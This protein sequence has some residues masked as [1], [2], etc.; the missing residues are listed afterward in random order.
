MPR[1]QRARNGRRTANATR[2]YNRKQQNNTP[3]RS[4]TLAQEKRN[5]L[6]PTSFES[7]KAFDGV[8]HATFKATCFALE[9]S[10]NDEQWKNSLAEA[11]L[12][13]SPS[14]LRELF[15]III[16][17]CQPSEPQFLWEQFRNEF[18]ED[19]LHTER[20]RL[21]DFLV[22]EK[23]FKNLI[24]ML[25]PGYVL[26]SRKSVS[27]SLLPQ[28]YESTVDN[29]KNKLKNVTAVCLTTDAWTSINNE[30]YVAVTAHY[31]DDDTKMSSILIGCQH[32]TAKHTA[33]EMSSPLKEQWRH[34]PCFAH[35]INLIVQSGLET[36]KLILNKVKAIVEYFK[37]ST[38][39]LSRLNEIQT[40]GSYSV[41]K[42]KQDCS[43][44]WNSTYD[45]VDRILKIKDP[46]LSTLAIIN[47]DLNTITFDEWNVLKVLCQIFYDVT[48]EISSENYISIS[49]VTIF[50]RAMVNYVS[51]FT[52]NSIMPTE[53]C[54]VAK[55]LKD[56]LHSRSDQL[57]NNEV[58]MQ[59]ILLDPRFKKQGFPNDQKYQSAYQSL[60]RKVQIVPIGQDA[61]EPEA[62]LGIGPLFGPET[63]W[64]DF[65][66]RVIAVSG[67]SNVTVAG[68][69]E[70][71]RYIAEP[72][73]KRT[74][75]PLVWWNERKLIYPKL[76][77]LVCRR[78]CIV[79]TSVPCERIFSKA[80]MVLTE[81]WSRLTIDKVEKLLF[82]N[83]NLD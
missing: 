7:L 66:T 72:L 39:A 68:I 23:E 6:S 57:K 78:L 74:E 83:H 53:I 48:N 15:A 56:K 8:I 79:A 31:I 51:G 55:I 37:R 47:N 25:A 43:T 59:S 32:F 62:T 70:L 2:M 11:T 44:K 10:E 26:P 81:R 60:S 12:S 36:V 14:K 17:F 33:V 22:E 80:G 54:S 64:K 46:V 76:Y 77:Q 38:Y 30:Y 67:G 49:K 45:M 61:Q 3:E 82:L 21:N 20:T 69:L 18:C 16:V 71:D 27:N 73:L 9:L 75:D 28:L 50:S 19:I 24:Q 34:F 29:I 35:S 1:A 42:L 13:E 40:Q 63:I 58:V 52:N 5:A 65:D 4:Q 41:L